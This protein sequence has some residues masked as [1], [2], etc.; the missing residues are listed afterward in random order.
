MGEE[1]EEEGERKIKRG[2]EGVGW[3]ADKRR[4][5]QGVFGL[6][7]HSLCSSRQQT[8]LQPW[9][10]SGGHAATSGLQASACKP[11]AEPPYCCPASGQ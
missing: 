7:V 6:N 5:I 11:L 8:S 2:G 1:E 10:V 3:G 4:S 9:Q